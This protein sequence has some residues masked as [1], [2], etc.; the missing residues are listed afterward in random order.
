[1]TTLRMDNAGRFIG[2]CV[3][4]KQ[5]YYAGSLDEMRGMY[6]KCRAGISCPIDTHS[7]GHPYGIPTMDHPVTAIHWR[8]VRARKSDRECD[9]RCQNAI[10][11]DCACEC[12]G[13]NH[14]AGW[15]AVAMNA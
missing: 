15:A 8:E 4:C 6:C 14:G 2:A 12:S 11:T 3:V 13:R 7:H 9:S 10:G 1:M 5:R